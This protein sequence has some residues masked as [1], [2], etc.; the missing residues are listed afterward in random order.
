[1]ELYLYSRKWKA[2]GR[3]SEVTEEV[4][5]DHGPKMGQRVIGGR[6]EAG[7]TSFPPHQPR[8]RGQGFSFTLLYFAIPGVT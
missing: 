7:N 6:E 1:V 5:G 4:W 3:K 2:A 8:W